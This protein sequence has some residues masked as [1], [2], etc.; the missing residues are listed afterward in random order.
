[1]ITSGAAMATLKTYGGQV[2]PVRN[3]L[4]P[5]AITGTLST[6]VDMPTEIYG[7][8]FQNYQ[9][10]SIRSF[11][12]MEWNVSLF[13]EF[14]KGLG[15]VN[16]GDIWIFVS[17]QRLPGPLPDDHDWRFLVEDE[18]VT[19]HFIVDSADMVNMTGTFF[20]G[21]GSTIPADLYTNE[22]KAVKY[23]Y[24]G[25][26]PLYFARELPFDYSIRVFDKGCY[27]F[28]D[29]NVGFNNYGQT[30][31]EY[32]GNELVRCYTNHLTP[33]SVSIHNP[34][35]SEFLAYVYLENNQPRS[36]VIL[37]ILTAFTIFMAVV[38]W[39]AS[40]HDLR[41]ISKG[42]IRYMKDNM[43]HADYK[44]LVAVE[45]GY[46]MFATTDSKVLM[47][48]IGD[49]G[50]E[51]ARELYGDEEMGKQFRWG[52]TDRF[53]MTT[54]WPLGAL[55]TIRIWTDES[56]QGHRQSWYCSRII[57]KDLQT[58]EIFEFRVNKWFGS[59]TYDGKTQKLV[60][61]TKKRN[62]NVLVDALSFHSL[63]D[64]ITYWNMF[65]GGGLLTRLRFDRVE[66][67]LNVY[68][69]VL[70]AMLTNILVAANESYEK[71]NLAS[72]SILG[73]Y[74]SWKDVVLGFVFS[75]VCIPTSI[76]IP[77]IHSFIP[78]MHKASEKGEN[79]LKMSK[80]DMR[81]RLRWWHRL[82][83]LIKYI[84]L[85]IA[86]AIAICIVQLA[87]GYYVEQT[88]AFSR[89]FIITLLFWI[90]F[91][92]P[93]KAFI[94]SLFCT[95]ACKNYRLIRKYEL[96]EIGE[97][98]S[99]IDVVP[100]KEFAGML[101]HNVVK[102]QCVSTTRDRRMRDE[103]LFVTTREVV[104]VF[105]SVAICL[106]FAFS[107]QDTAAYY[108][109][110]ELRNLLRA[111]SSQ[112][113]MQITTVAEFWHYMQV[114]FIKAT[115]VS[116]YDGK[117]AWGMRGFM[118]DKVSRMMGYGIVRQVRSITNRNC[119]VVKQFEGFFNACDGYTRRKLEDTTAAYNVG[120]NEVIDVSKAKPQYIYHSEEALQGRPFYGDHD[121]YSGGGY[122]QTLN[123]S[124][125]DLRAAFTKLENESWINEGTRAVFIEFSVY[126]AQTNH[127]SVIQLVLEIP[128]F[129]T[130]FPTASI[131]IVRLLKNVGGEHVN[132]A[133]LFEVL[134]IL[135]CIVLALK[136]LFVLISCSPIEY[137]SSFW[138][139]VDLTIAACAIAS[140][141]SYVFRQIGINQAIAMFMAMNGNGYIRLDRQRDLQLIFLALLSAVVFLTCMKMIN[142]LRFNRRIGLFTQTLSHSAPTMVIF[143]AVFCIVS[144]AFDSALF[145][146]LAS[147]L[148][149]YRNLTT[150]AKTTII[151]L[152]GK[153]SAT[154]I[155]AISPFG[156]A[157]Y[158]I[159]I[160]AGKIGLLNFFVMLVMTEFETL[161]RDPKNQSNDYEALDHIASKALKVCKQ[162]RRHHLPNLGFPDTLH[163]SLACDRLEAKVCSVVFALLLFTANGATIKL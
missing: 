54:V 8:D 50:M 92:E 125:E 76:L 33:F 135:L 61:V 10:L 56:G 27:Y 15:S 86:I 24:N 96:P 29:N 49:K 81:G 25:S 83:H 106:G 28:A 160:L 128:P 70:L 41:D 161:R 3:A 37:V 144:L 103:Q 73:Y 118:N 159:F 64:H 72:I 68:L 130:V 17:F 19:N 107:S 90:L 20:I 141:I 42:R 154:D 152:L 132:T 140:L 100:K 79:F 69:A 38:T 145:V 162:Y 91:T 127:F 12:T 35:I 133:T 126:N 66:R 146:I 137:F 149:L 47:N 113:F 105:V 43:Y 89:R 143:G 120:W 85:A 59:Q 34:H 129:G 121:S 155:A 11:F 88:M 80:H 78:V 4:W 123:G 13:I 26:A 39:L 65:T 22:T 58:N 77:Y 7:G 142:I 157:V 94:C 131:Q 45:T 74:F 99:A 30:V 134:Y 138:N 110:V 93:L 44:Y 84:E 9:V 151:S 158:I 16:G 150:V 18:R 82:A 48:V 117:P 1:M 153:L 112:A 156:A 71:V 109:Q 2:I 136:E 21:V 51:V 31:G 101:E 87:F 46:R 95:V 119:G 57:F 114:E 148:Q 122:I 104:F 111:G 97:R 115:R 36:A 40:H 139:Y 53:L 23:T 102:L 60:H 124:S 116:W 52:T 163:T 108:Y 5:I 63:A 55:Q 14:K 67:V 147:R 98:I 32:V 75:W 6:A 62:C